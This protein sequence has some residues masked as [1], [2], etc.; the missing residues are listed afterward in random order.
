MTFTVSIT[1]SKFFPCLV[2]AVTLEDQQISAIEGEVVEVCVQITG[3][4]DRNLT[5]L[6]TTG[7]GSATRKWEGV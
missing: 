6:L 5:V 3:A 4:L 1:Q 2:V 7:T